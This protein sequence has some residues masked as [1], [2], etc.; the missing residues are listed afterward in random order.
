METYIK[1][2]KPASVMTATQVL[3]RLTVLPKMHIEVLFHT[4]LSYYRVMETHPT[5]STLRSQAPIQQI[6]DT[7]AISREG[8]LKL[9][10]RQ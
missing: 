2:G 5:L 3:T 6:H 10:D 8:Q 1:S 4:L 9:E 7:R